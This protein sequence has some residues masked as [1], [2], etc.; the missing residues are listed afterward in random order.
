MLEASRYTCESIHLR[1]AYVWRAQ[2]VLYIFSCRKVSRRKQ[3]PKHETKKGTLALPN[4]GGRE[5]VRIAVHNT[6]ISTQDIFHT[7][8]NRYWSLVIFQ[9]ATAI[10]VIIEQSHQD[11]R[12]C[13][14]HHIIIPLENVMPRFSTL[15]MRVVSAPFHHHQSFC[16][17]SITSGGS[18]TGPERRLTVKYLT[19]LIPGGIASISVGLGGKLSRCSDNTFSTDS[20]GMW[21]TS[22][23]RL[24]RISGDALGVDGSFPNTFRGWSGKWLIIARRVWSEIILP[25]SCRSIREFRETLTVTVESDSCREKY[26]HIFKKQ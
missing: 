5:D 14:N 18:E 8:W 3:V 19:L 12:S 23:I 9:R 7:T 13:T 16:C 22:A 24:T 11:T 6:C 10:N 2:A 17:A 26:K 4:H 1:E 20:I 25:L 21:L 15:T